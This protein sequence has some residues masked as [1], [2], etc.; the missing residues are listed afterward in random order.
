MKFM[1]KLSLPKLPN[2]QTNA[3]TNAPTDTNDDKIKI[4]ETMKNSANI[5]KRKMTG[6]E[7]SEITHGSMIIENTKDEN[8]NIKLQSSN[9]ND[10]IVYLTCDQG[11]LLKKVILS[12]IAN[13][14]KE[15]ET[16][17]R[18][19]QKNY[20]KKIQNVSIEKE[21]SK[22][23]TNT[24]DK[25]KNVY[26]KEKTEFDTMLDEFKKNIENIKIEKNK[27]ITGTINLNELK[28]TIDCQLTGHVFDT[29][30][31]NNKNVTKREGKIELIDLKAKKIYVTVKG[32]EK[33]PKKAVSID[34][35]C[36]K[37]DSENSETFQ[38]DGE[39]QMGGNKKKSKNNYSHMK[40]ISDNSVDICE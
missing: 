5:I 28:S 26:D 30:F 10:C 21:I 40:I 24:I 38:C 29:L 27:K 12:F 2:A 6:A 7:K 18:D 35:I 15:Y 16:K 32:N 37:S 36:I 19:E 9:E 13:Q 25:L 31:S 3:Q 8:T 4:S 11:K 33:G 23:K 20:A 1:P 22:I 17:L 14:K 39:N 34:N